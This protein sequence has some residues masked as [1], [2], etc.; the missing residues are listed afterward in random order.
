MA[1][2]KPGSSRPQKLQRIQQLVAE[3]RLVAMVGDGIN[4]AALAAASVGIAM[5]SGTVVAHETADVILIC[6]DLSRLVDNLDL[7]RRTEASGRTSNPR[8]VFSTI[9]P[10][11]DRAAPRILG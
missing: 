3:G 1:R 2:S 6:N 7:A 5:G 11:G 4:E 10:S 8:R 9:G